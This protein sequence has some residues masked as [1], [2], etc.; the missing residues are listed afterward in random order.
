MNSEQFQRDIQWILD[1]PDLLEGDAN[2]LRFPTN[3]ASS[4]EPFAPLSHKV[5]VYFE[6][7]VARMLWHSRDH[8]LHDQSVQIIREGRTLGELDFIY[9]DRTGVVTHCEVAIKYY[10]YYPQDN[11]TG[12]H[13]IG[14]NPKDTFE[15]KVSRLISH[16]IPLSQKYYP[17]A[18]QRESFVKGIIFYPY[19]LESPTVNPN[20]LAQDHF[21]GTWLYERDVSKL[22][23]YTHD[24]YSICKKPN[25][26][27]PTLDETAML[28][29]KRFPD[30]VTRYFRNKR[31]PLMV[32]RLHDKRG[33]WVEQ[34]RLFIVPNQWP[35]S[36]K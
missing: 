24:V 13:F 29:P 20:H 8:R 7:L 32:S 22:A 30:W 34:D 2:H 4:G 10:L 33:Q 19:D 31:Q 27:S 1:C 36:S 9:D 12:S 25:W 35:H 6:A 5:G 16:Q 15:N 23:D 28:S 26:L 17:A 11:S 14:P 3:T 18:K 21:R